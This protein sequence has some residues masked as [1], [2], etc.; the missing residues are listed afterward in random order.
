M[1][2]NGKPKLLF[3]AAARDL[4]ELLMLTQQAM[5]QRLGITRGHIHKI[6]HDEARPSLDLFDRWRE[7]FGGEFDLYM[8]AY[9]TMYWCKD[10]RPAPDTCRERMS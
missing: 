10:T 9:V 5:A 6:E 1:E 7:A 8:E 4:R 2:G 3:G